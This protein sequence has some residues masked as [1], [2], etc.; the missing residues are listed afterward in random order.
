VVLPAAAGPPEIKIKTK[1][2]KLNRDRIRRYFILSP[3]LPEFDR[4]D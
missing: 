1:K 3:L 2:D 4:R